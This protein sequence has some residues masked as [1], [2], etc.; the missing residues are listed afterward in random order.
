MARLI[1]AV[2]RC[3]LRFESGLPHGA[4]ERVSLCV[5]ASPVRVSV[6]RC[7]A[8][9]IAFATC[10]SLSLAARGRGTRGE[11]ADTKGW[12]TRGLNISGVLSGLCWLGIASTRER[13]LYAHTPTG[14][15]MHRAETRLS[16]SSSF[17]VFFHHSSTCSC[18][19]GK[20]GIPPLFTVCSSVYS[21]AV[22][23][24]TRKYS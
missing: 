1:K 9:Y 7:A 6:H 22:G 11:R 5:H 14:Y 19:D 12:R 17:L 20:E 23:R 15:I 24:M 16:F 4:K 10:L 18:G 3:G 13:P 2:A 8:V 21:F